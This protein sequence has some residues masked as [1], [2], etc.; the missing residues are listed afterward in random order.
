[1]GF[2]LKQTQENII[3][4]QQKILV[5]KSTLKNGE[6]QGLASIGGRSPGLNG[7]GDATMVPP[8]V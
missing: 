1:M 8:L 2:G 5:S 4:K 6:D 7:S 3:S